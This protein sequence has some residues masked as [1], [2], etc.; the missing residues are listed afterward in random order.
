MCEIHPRIKENCEVVVPVLY[1]NHFSFPR[2]LTI[3]LK[4]GDIL[5][6]AP[7]SCLIFI[8]LFSISI[9]SYGGHKYVARHDTAPISP[10]DDILHF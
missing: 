8:F 4:G 7:K 1:I 10:F 3:N 6:V 5:H 9:L 2:N